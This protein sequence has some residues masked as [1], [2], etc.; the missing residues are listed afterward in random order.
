MFES[1]DPDRRYRRLSLWH[2]TYPGSLAPRPS[3]P[4]DR[5]VDVAIVGAGFTG[6][7][8]AYYLKLLDPG[9]RI[10]VVEREIAGFGASG[11]NGGWCVA[12]F[13]ASLRRLARDVDPERV[14]ALQGALDATVD[15][16]G[17]VASAEGID[18][19][20]RKGGAI[21][22]ARNHAQLTRA[23]DDVA[24]A[25]SHGLGEDHVRLLDATEARRRLGG[26]RILGATYLP[27]CAALD[28]LRLV[29]GLADA[30]ERLG[31]PIHEGT[32]VTA[33]GPG[34]VETPLG[35]IRA[36]VVV[37]ALEGYTPDI[38]GRRRDILPMY[39]L[40][41]ATEP[42]PADVLARIG[43][44]E[45]ETFTD[46]RHLKIYGQLTA[47]GRIAFGG[48]GAPYHFGSAVRPGFDRDDR[49]HRMLRDVLRDLLPALG[50]ARFTHAWGG[51]LGI[52]RDWYPSVGF[53]RRSGL[54]WAGGYVGD[55]VATSNLAARTVADLVLGRRSELTDL[56]WVGHR[57]PRWE[58]EPLRWLGVN[59]VTA[60][61]WAGDRLEAVTGRPAAP[62]RWFWR[63]LGH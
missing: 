60:L 35:T 4:G 28:P 56:P 6:L 55:G 37:P 19:R 12:I 45:R 46:K 62:V 10:E 13:P 9:L 48:R 7:W 52:P 36:D 24:A 38:P 59:A 30:V 54:A 57:S 47:D 40:M 17:R 50:D 33:I 3:L 2:D 18:C 23:R 63:S 51:N 21:S 14:L 39:S 61:M 25:R 58:P 42:L 29:R 41:V 31:V 26:S 20:F 27:H 34:R 5:Q 49:V 44:G 15:E 53:D 32:P 1:P 22:V 43:L 16:V 8:T 11:R